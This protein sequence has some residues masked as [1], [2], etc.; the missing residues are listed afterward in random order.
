[1]VAT[2]CKHGKLA[3]PVRENGKMR[4]CK[5]APKTSAGRKADRKHKS[6]EFH[7][8]RY[9]KDKRKKAAGSSK[10]R[11]AKGVVKSGPRKG[12]CKKR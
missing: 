4:R 11:C 10:K 2:K 9:R 3:K 6:T 1:M 12:K 7:E 8:V 5:L